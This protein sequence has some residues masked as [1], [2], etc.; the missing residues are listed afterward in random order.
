MAKPA[1]PVGTP[2]RYKDGWQVPSSSGPGVYFVR[3]G[4]RPQCQCGAWVFGHG[5]PCR[6]IRAVKKLLEDGRGDA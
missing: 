5:S 3:L 6:H 4:P 2:E 1:A